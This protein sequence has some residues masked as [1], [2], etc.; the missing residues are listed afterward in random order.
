MYPACI[1]VAS[2]WGAHCDRIDLFTDIAK[3]P[4][5]DYR[6]AE[7]A[8]AKGAEGKWNP[9]VRLSDDSYKS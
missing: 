6:S 1:R 4:L 5:T 7:A 2:K 3:N 8:I 9:L